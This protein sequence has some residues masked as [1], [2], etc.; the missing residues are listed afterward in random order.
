MNYVKATTNIMCSESFL[1]Q[2]LACE[3]SEITMCL[4]I[5]SRGRGEG[6]GGW[7]EERGGGNMEKRNNFLGYRVCL[8]YATHF[9]AA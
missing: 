1:R 2:K 8:L 7:S 3:T 4:R 6:R 5:V 9:S